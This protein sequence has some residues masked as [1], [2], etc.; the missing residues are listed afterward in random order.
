MEARRWC[1]A[2]QE[3]AENESEHLNTNKREIE[4]C[5]HES[6]SE[7][8]NENESESGNLFENYTEI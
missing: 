7:N 2:A 5:K 8:V 1:A 6:E 3:S 4:H